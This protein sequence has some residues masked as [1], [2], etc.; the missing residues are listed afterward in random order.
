[1]RLDVGVLGAEQLAGATAGEVL[2]PVDDRVA[3]VVALARVALGVLVGKHGPG[4]RHD[5]RGGE[6]FRGDQLECGVLPLLLVLDYCEE[7]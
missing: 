2:R 6:V 3:A 5:S 4:R 7:L 1:V